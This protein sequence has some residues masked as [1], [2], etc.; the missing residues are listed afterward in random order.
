[1]IL[2]ALVKYYET[3]LKDGKAV[4]EGWCSAKVS[5]ALNLSKEGALQSVIP[6]KQPQERG[7]KRVYQK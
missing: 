1:M 6:L 3:L 7:K 4:P 5:Y 2:Q